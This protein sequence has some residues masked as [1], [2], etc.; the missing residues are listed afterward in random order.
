M[1]TNEEV[2]YFDKLKDA[3]INM[4]EDEAA[5]L[6]EEI[7]QKG[8]N[9]SGAIKEGLIAGMEEVS[10]LYAKE[11]YFIPELLL[12]ADAMY[13]ALIPLKAAVPTDKVGLNKKIVIGTIFGDTHDIGKNIVAL[14]LESAGFEVIDL[15][16]DVSADTFVEQAV[17]INADLIV[18]STLMT[19]TMNHMSAVIDLLEEKC[20]RDRFKVM[21]G[22]RPLSLSFAKKIG[23]DGYSANAAAAVSL[24]KKLTHCG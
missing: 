13:A 14:F 6:A 17:A 10:N 3:V 7:I 21:I 18:I 11:E 5:L 2:L 23:A 22:G 4:D 8:Y 16:R 24:A 12:C 19:T 20:L 9:A 15:G 1:Y